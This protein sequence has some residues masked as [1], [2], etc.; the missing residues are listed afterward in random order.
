MVIQGSASLQW[1]GHETQ[2]VW[3]RSNKFEVTETG[4]L[5]ISVWLKTETPDQQPPLRLALEGRSEGSSYYRFGS[6]GSLSPDSEANQIEERWKR[7]AVHFDDLPSEGLTDVRI[8][9][10]LMGPGQVTIDNVEVF[11]RWFDENDVKAMTQM[12]ASTTPLLSDPMGYE[13]CRQLMTSY[14]PKFLDQYIVLNEV[15]SGS[16][17]SGTSETAKPTKDGQLGVNTKSEEDR[18]IQEIEEPKVPMFRRIRNLVPQRK[19]P[20]K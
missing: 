19:S 20:V 8:G 4:R 14:W 17:T 11:D 6:V 5:S 13:R 1:T 7:F 3:V 18:E 15:P 16:E 2:V 10:D 9:F 12:L